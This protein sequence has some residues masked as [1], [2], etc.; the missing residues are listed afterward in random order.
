MGG[1]AVMTHEE[2]VDEIISVSSDPRAMIA[3]LAA[4]AAT[5]MVTPVGVMG[6]DVQTWGDY[7]NAIAD[8]IAE[9][10]D[11]ETPNP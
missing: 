3:S 4:E 2:P 10:V 11:R 1:L 6:V 5:L 8:I 9:Y 7:F